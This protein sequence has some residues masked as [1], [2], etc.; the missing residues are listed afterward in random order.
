MQKITPFLW[1]NDQAE[2]AAHFYASIFK[3]GKVGP[4][5]RYD[6]ASA[7]ASGRL[8]GSVMTVTFELCGLHFA[9]LNGG[10]I[11]QFTPALSFFVNCETEEEVDKLWNKLS[12]GGTVMMELQRYPWSEKYGW[13]AD[14]YGVSWQISLA[15]T[16]QSITPSFLFT[17]K[18]YTKAEEAMN[19]Y[20]SLFKDSKV[21]MI[22][23]NGPENKTEKEGTIQ[24]ASFTLAGQNFNIMEGSVGDNAYTP[25]VSLV[26]NCDTQEEIDHFWN[27]LSSMKEAEQCGW[28]VDRY[29]VSWQIIPATQQ[30]MLTGDPDAAH[31]VMKEVLKMKKI[32]LATLRKAYQSAD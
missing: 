6:D 15:K 11:F 1:F 22:S 23:R 18:L 13:T 21:N 25:A 9:A 7:H 32:D 3:N 17:G 16:P 26:V 20:L 2:E 12:D 14:R 8:E 5:V 27:A 30:E 31:R 10:P 24:Y 29:G 4:I 28:C 19:F